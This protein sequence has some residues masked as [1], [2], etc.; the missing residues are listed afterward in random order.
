M[1]LHGLLGIGGRRHCKGRTVNH[2]APV[3]LWGYI[4]DR[5]EESEFLYEFCSKEKSFFGTFGSFLL[6]SFWSARK[7]TH[8]S[9]RCFFFQ[10]CLSKCKSLTQSAWGCVPLNNCLSVIV[11]HTGCVQ[12][13]LCALCFYPHWLVCF[14]TTFSNPNWFCSDDTIILRPS[15]TVGCELEQKEQEF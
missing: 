11:L 5:G 1:G 9:P 6:N 13:D 8:S 10:P 7:T 14:L 15:H 3:C 2:W 12:G 4:W